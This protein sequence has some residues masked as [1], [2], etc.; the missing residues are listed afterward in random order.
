[1]RSVQIW[2]IKLLA[3]QTIQDPLHWL[4]IETLPFLSL[5]A[6]MSCNCQKS[7]VADALDDP[8]HLVFVVVCPVVVYRMGVCPMALVYRKTIDQEAIFCQ[9]ANAYL[10]ITL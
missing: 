2:Q 6:L 5:F 1:M 4:Q 7:A 9:K 8:F 10:C 3:P